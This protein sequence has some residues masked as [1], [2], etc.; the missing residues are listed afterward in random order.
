[1]GSEHNI[2]TT[3]KKKYN[4]T[5]RWAYPSPLLMALLAR[6]EAIH[7]PRQPQV[8]PLNAVQPITHRG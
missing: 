1:L 3:M 8:N 4:N 2:G 7:Y 6:F 5:Q